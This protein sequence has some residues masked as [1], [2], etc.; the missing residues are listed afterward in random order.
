M[1]AFLLAAGEGRR[2]RPLT[3]T[4]P[5]CLVPIGGVPLLEIWMALLARHGVTDVLVNLH[6][7]HERVQ[8]FVDSLSTT[9]RIQTVH[10]PALLGSGGTVWANRSFVE[11]EE[12]FLV[13]YADNLTRLDLTRMIAF[14][15]T[16]DAPLTMGLAVTDRPREKGTAV[17]D[18]RQRVVEFEEKAERPRSNM[19]NVGIYLARQALFGYFPKALPP[20]G[21][22]DFGHDVLPKMVPDIVGYQVDEFLIDIGTHENYAA[23]QRLWAP[24]GLQPQDS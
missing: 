6:H 19:A 17:L 4:V 3:N 7:G 24:A 18:R 14:H 20:G 1:K 15:R 8:R 23:A 21:I 16:H 9:L 5:K 11:A 22:V 10:E 12:S 2:L 13:A